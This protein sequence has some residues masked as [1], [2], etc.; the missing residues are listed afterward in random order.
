V[1]RRYRVDITPEAQGDIQAV[2]DFIALDRPQAATRWAKEARRLIRSL[3]TFPER[4][5][6]IPETEEMV[7]AR[8]YRHLL[9]GNYRIIYCV[10]ETRVAVMRVVHA[11]RQLTP[12]MLRE[13][14]G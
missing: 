11:A 10:Q 3:G 7:F 12:E 9:F 14:S 2:R 5:E 4:Y 8:D 6:I 1:P 13:A